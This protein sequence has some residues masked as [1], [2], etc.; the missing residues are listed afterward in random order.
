MDRCWENGARCPFLRRHQE[1]HLRSRGLKHLHRNDPPARAHAESR[2]LPGLTSALRSGDAHRNRFRQSSWIY[3]GEL[4][5]VD[6]SVPGNYR[7]FPVLNCAWS[8]S[9]PATGTID[10]KDARCNIPPIHA[11]F[12]VSVE[13]SGS[14][15]GEVQSS[16]AH[17]STLSGP[18]EQ[19]L[20]N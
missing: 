11:A 6:F 18:D 2:C 5:A 3:L 14:D 16:A 15:V 17:H 4:I 7:E 20:K 10:Q 12:D 1:A 8:D 9:Q 13:S 19:I